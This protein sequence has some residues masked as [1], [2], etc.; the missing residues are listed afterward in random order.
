MRVFCALTACA[1]AFVA[2]VVSVLDNAREPM[3][4]FAAA[5]VLAAI[6]AWAGREPYAGGRRAI[7]TGIAF[8][9][10]MAAAWIGLLLLAY[11]GASWPPPEPEATYLGLT[12]TIY[13]LVALYGG[14]VL[15]TL[16]G[17][18]PPVTRRAE[19]KAPAGSAGRGSRP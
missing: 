18:W 8:V 9:W 15:V 17:L 6:Q 19:S 2:V 4:F 10:L 3:A 16:A 13:H 5:T 11:Q 1:L 14:A 12:A 7:G